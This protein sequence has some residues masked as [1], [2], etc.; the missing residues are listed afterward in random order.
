MYYAITTINQI[1]AMFVIILFGVIFYK[2]G[3][4]T[5]EGNKSM[6]NIL[7]YL[8]NPALAFNAF[9]REFDASVLKSLGM[10]VFLSLLAIGISIVVSRPFFRRGG[11]NTESLALERFA[12]I[13]TNCGF[14][15]IPLM[16]GLFGAEGVLYASVYLIVYN[17]VI[18]SHGLSMIT[19]RT[20]KKSLMEPFRTPIVPAVVLGFLCFLSGFRL[21]APIQ[22][23]MDFSG[24]LNTPLAMLVAGV[25]IAQSDGKAMIKRKRIYYTAFISLLVI[26]L[27]MIGAFRFLPGYHMVKTAVL[28]AT[29]CPAGAMGTMLAIRYDR[30]HRYYSQI[31][32]MTTL[33]SIFTLPLMLAIMQ[34]I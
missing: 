21:P 13:Y 12:C 16:N 23:G 31:F 20:D 32:A 34:M 15:G 17:L 4:I 9:Q 30:D 11:E 7:L 24:S 18:W 33:L 2:K 1:V 29:A 3:M 6:S 22:T 19:G 14:F 10:A 28:V 25:S 5:E 26:P 8:V 27:L